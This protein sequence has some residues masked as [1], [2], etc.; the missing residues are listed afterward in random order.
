M[1]SLPANGPEWSW[2]CH[3]TQLEPG[4]LRVLWWILDLR[5]ALLATATINCASLHRLQAPAECVSILM[6]SRN[7]AP[8][9]VAGHE[10][11]RG[12][13]LLLGAGAE[14]ELISHRSSQV[15]L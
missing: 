6:R 7:A 9:Y 5:D 4:E 15:L 11:R 10:L 2:R 14:L 8:L 13:C 3:S 12:R 1:R